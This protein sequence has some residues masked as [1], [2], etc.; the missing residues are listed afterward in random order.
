MVLGV[1]LINLFVLG[2]V[3]FSLHQS[4]GEFNERAEITA[5]NLAQMLAQD[6][7]REFEKIDVTLL[8]AVD[9][10]ER[11]LAHGGINRQA[12]DAYFG[13]LQGRVPEIISLRT[14]DAAGIVGYGLG[15][16]P[17]A[18]PNN[19]DREYF[20][21]QRDNPEARLVVAKP[22]LARIDKRWVIP[23]SRRIHMPDGSFGGVVYVNVALDSLTQTFANLDV[24][25]H[26]SVSLRDSELRIFARYPVPGDVDKVLGQKL[27]VPELQKLIVSGRD[28]GTYISAIRIEGGQEKFVLRQFL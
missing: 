15:V 12:I 18:R 14:T 16:D 9:E 25:K 8:S 23:I 22:V 11:Q 17:K 10:F 7:G 2:M 5:Q 20:I 13:R 21:R 4:F 6:I 19:S 28:I 27:A 26:G 1:A 3:A 24:G